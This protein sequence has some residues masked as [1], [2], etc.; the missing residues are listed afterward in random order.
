M[1]DSRGK[2]LMKVEENTDW[3]RSVFMSA[4]ATRVISGS[5]YRSI[6]IWD[7]ASEKDLTKLEVHTGSVSSVFMSAN[8]TDAALKDVAQKCPLLHHLFLR[9]CMEVR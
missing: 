1:F 7:A 2:K 4:D 9:G 5:N 6:G 3:V 8:V